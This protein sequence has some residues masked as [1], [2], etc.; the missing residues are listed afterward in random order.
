MATGGDVF[1]LDMG[2]P[3]R[4]VDLAR[5]MVEL[6]GLSVRDENNPEGDIEITVTGLR[7]GEKLYEELLIGENPVPTQHPRI[8]KAQE[9]FLPWSQLQQSLGALHIAKGVNDVALIRGL[10]QQLLS[11]Y[12]PT[13]EVVD[14]VYLAQDR[15]A[16][17]VGGE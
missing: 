3:V 6:S 16:V 12:H 1:V 5:R 9:P 4:I 10:L 7:P 8:M 15:E 13:G 17:A 11:G 14:W 2:Q